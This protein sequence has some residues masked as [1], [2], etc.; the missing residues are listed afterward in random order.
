MRIAMGGI[1]HE[2]NTFSATLTN[3]AAF[4]IQRDADIIQWWQETHHEV[5]GFIEGASKFGYE[6][7]PTLMAMATPSGPVTS[8][9]FEAL[10]DE[11]ID[12]LTGASSLDGLLL[13][14]HGAMVSEEHPDGDGEVVR[15][16]R[17]ALGKDFP[18][19]V[20][21]D[22]HANVS[23]QIVNESTALVIY[24]TYPHV[25][26]RERGL[27]A[28]EIIAGLVRGEIKPVQ[29]LSKPAMLLNIVRQNTNVEPIRSIM[30]AARALELSPKVLAASVALG[31]QYADV[32][33]IGPTVVVVT[34]RDLAL[35]KR[36]ARRLSDMLWNIREQLTFNLPDAAEAVWQAKHSEELPVVLVEMGDNIG[37]G[38]AGDSTFILDELLRQKAEGWVVVLAD[39]QAA[40]ECVQ[41]GVGASLTLRVGGKKD[42]LHGD[43]VEVSGRVKCLHDGQFQ[44]SE[45][46]HGGQRYY[47]QG[48]TAVLEIPTSKSGGQPSDCSSLLVLT[49]HRQV[50]FSLH[51]LLSVGIQ[52][53]QQ[54][55]LVVKAAI[56]FRA[57]YEPIA[58]RIIEV[59]TPGLTAVNPAR[60][61]YKHVRR[62][63]WGLGEEGGGRGSQ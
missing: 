15:R 19:V 22:L 50:P 1:M 45:P 44:E 39:P 42:N 29:A 23:E 20:T 57:A 36:E 49:T 3:L 12:R 55:I 48:L 47:D 37:G 35:A 63:L 25:D 60:F 14:L 33:E 31:Y 8:E 46:R 56:A 62:P 24:K 30:Q 34:D 38:S 13:A 28:A 26:H 17:A 9:A 7:F 10:T 59:D 2:S 41:A 51:Q 43:P 58:G 16:L 61:P 5:G 11:L 18:I 53:Q 4:Q 40:Q 27:Q 32:Y 21:H 52:P 54:K 6:L